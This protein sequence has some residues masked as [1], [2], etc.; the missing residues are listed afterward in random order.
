MFWVKERQ[1][2]ERGY[3][4]VEGVEERSNCISQLAKEAHAR[5]N[6]IDARIPRQHPLKNKTCV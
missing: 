1:T 3:G 2:I 5:F 6:Y 4:N